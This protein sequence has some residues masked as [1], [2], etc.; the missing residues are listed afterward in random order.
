MDL[1]RAEQQLATQCLPWRAL[2]GR[3]RLAW[4][5]GSGLLGGV[6]LATVPP[7]RW[8]RLGALLFGNG[9]ALLRSPLGLPLLGALWTVLQDTQPNTAAAAVVPASPGT[10]P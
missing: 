1:D 2:L 4:L 6:A 3:H 9:A 8:S 10:T 7:K 5:I